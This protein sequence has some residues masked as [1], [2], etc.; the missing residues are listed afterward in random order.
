MPH[1]AHASCAWPHK[2]EGLIPTRT[3]HDNMNDCLIAGETIARGIPELAA[4]DRDFLFI[5]V[6]CHHELEVVMLEM[7]PEGQP[8]QRK[9]SSQH[10]QKLTDRLDATGIDLST[11][12]A[13]D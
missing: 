4:H 8:R 9:L 11:S 1:P 3:V 5:E 12:L 6:V 2:L 13:T 7:S 10:R